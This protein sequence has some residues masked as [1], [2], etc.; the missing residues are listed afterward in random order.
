MSLLVA[1]QT[2]FRLNTTGDAV[3]WERLVLLPLAYWYGWALCTPLIFA[4]ARRLTPMHH[5]W[6][7][8]ITGHVVAALAFCVA[9]LAWYAFLMGAILGAS[10]GSFDQL[11]LRYL[12]LGFHYDLLTY[13]AILG[14]G[15]A[16]NYRAL[17]RER[18]HRALELEHRL[19]QA[20]MEVLRMQLRP[21]FL[22]NTL[23]A[24]ASLV[25]DDP[26]GARR[27]IARL[28]GLLRQTLDLGDR[29]EISLREE[30]EIVDAYLD[31]ESCRFQDRMQVRRALD[32]A[33]LHALVPPLLLQPLVENA[34][35]YGVEQSDGRCRIEL[36]ARR[37]AGDLEL[38]VRDRGPGLASSPAD[39]EAGIGVANVRARLARMYPDRSSLALLPATGGGVR[40]V[41]RMPF[42]RSAS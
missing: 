37:A 16:I 38:E 42:A 22:F 41:V 30:L 20:Q 29:R 34:V 14:T 13:A 2:L 28:S 31:I 1:T 21:H 10:E 27:M 36:S 8:L 3:T 35:R 23:H 7:V 32:P 33:C 18:D 17:F 5:R 40:A 19:V 39:T 6:P 11:F 25:E 4:A 26:A 24:I 12:A 9:M 15:F